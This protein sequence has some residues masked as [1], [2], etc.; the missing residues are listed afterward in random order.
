LGQ[1]NADCCS[2]EYTYNAHELLPFGWVFFYFSGQGKK[3]KTHTVGVRI[4]T[5]IDRFSREGLGEKNKLFLGKFSYSSSLSDFNREIHIPARVGLSSG[6]SLAE[7]P[8]RLLFGYLPP[9]FFYTLR[10]PCNYRDDGDSAPSSFSSA[11]GQSRGTAAGRESTAV[12][13]TRQT[14]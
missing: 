10:T 5:S 12:G 11:C 8:A 14:L 4:V 6:T 13:S 2:T 7:C 3:N 9:V 1:G